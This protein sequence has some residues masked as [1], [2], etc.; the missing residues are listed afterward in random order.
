[1]FMIP[2]IIERESKN[3]E[4]ESYNAIITW[5]IHTVDRKIVLA[6]EII[7]VKKLISNAI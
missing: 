2:E 7:R 4:I 1:M 5:P 3:L 6:L